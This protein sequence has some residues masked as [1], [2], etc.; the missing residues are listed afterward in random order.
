MG[1][2]AGRQRRED[3]KAVPEHVRGRARQQRERP[4]AARGGE[5]A[6]RAGGVSGPIRDRGRGDVQPPAWPGRA[7]GGRGPGA[8][9]DVSAGREA[10]AAARGEEPKPEPDGQGD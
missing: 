2:V 4:P 8:R 1:R 7:A 3:P 5:P 6:G 10:D 9:E